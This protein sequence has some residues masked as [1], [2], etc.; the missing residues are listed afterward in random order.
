V[1]L[2]GGFNEA[3][4]VDVTTIFCGF[5]TI[6]IGVFQLNSKSSQPESNLEEAELSS[7]SSDHENLRM[8]HFD[9]GIY[10]QL[11]EE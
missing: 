7:L 5:L 10:D 2:F 11:E 4:G 8:D 9:K 3:S 1:L 6:F